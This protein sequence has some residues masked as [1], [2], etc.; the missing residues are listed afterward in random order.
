M[1]WLLC[2]QLNKSSTVAASLSRR[3]SISSKSYSLSSSASPPR[4]CPPSLC[5]SPLCSPSS[6]APGRSPSSSSSSPCSWPPWYLSSASTSMAPPFRPSCASA[7]SAAPPLLLPFLGTTRSPSSTSAP[8]LDLL[9]LPCGVACC[10]LGCGCC[11]C[12]CCSSS[13]LSSTLAVPLLPL[14]TPALAPFALA[15][16]LPLFM[17]LSV[18]PSSLI[19]APPFSSVCASLSPTPGSRS[20]GWISTVEGAC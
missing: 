20:A 1:D 9:P 17:P 5:A 14:S 19:S 15:P 4:R 8:P 13:P 18:P 7:A 2:G 6:A 3:P 16:L 11:C 10:F 12:C